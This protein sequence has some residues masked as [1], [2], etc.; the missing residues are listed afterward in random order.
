LILAD[1]TEWVKVFDPRDCTL[2]ARCEEPPDVGVQTRVDLTVGTGGPRVILHGRV[3]SR[4]AGSEDSGSRGCSIAIGFEDREKINY[5]N[6]YV[7][8]G[9]LDLRQK[10]RLPIRLAVTYGGLEGPRRSF[11]R[12]INEEGVFIVT[13]NPLPE[14]SVVHLRLEM[15]AR[16]AVIALVGEVTHTVLV[17]DEDVPGMGIVF[18]FEDGEV[19]PFK[20][21][22]DEL[23]QSF[24]SGRLPE[25]VLL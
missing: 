25:E 12:D 3:I 24:V 18:R 13:E 16:A 19:E 5:L 21:A 14:Q 7:R 22:I 15:P 6:G 9:L 10:R 17:E 1:K 11:T 23:E 4:R 2:F 8:G 20:N